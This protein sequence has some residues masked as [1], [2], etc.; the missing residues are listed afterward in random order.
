MAEVWA[1]QC[2]GVVRLLLLTPTTPP[3]TQ[4]AC[5]F[6]DSLGLVDSLTS[7]M[8]GK[9]SVP[10]SHFHVTSIFASTGSDPGSVLCFARHFTAR[11]HYNGLYSSL[12]E[13]E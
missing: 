8:Q 4:I 9:V 5:L 3:G 1:V 7:L 12:R 6:L 10:R 11:C 2:L 13:R